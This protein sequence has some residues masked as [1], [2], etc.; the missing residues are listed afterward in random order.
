[1]TN[2]KSPSPKSKPDSSGLDP[3]INVFARDSTD[4]AERDARIES[5]HDEKNWR[6]GETAQPTQNHANSRNRTLERVPAGLDEGGD[7]RLG[8]GA[9]VAENLASGES[10]KP[11][12][13]G[14]VETAREP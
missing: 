14:E 6:V 12:A 2:S 9:V 8:A 11:A 13:A 5:G 3:A 10:R 1:M 7:V 4:L